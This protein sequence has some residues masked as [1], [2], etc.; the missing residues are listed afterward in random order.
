MLSAPSPTCVYSILM[1]HLETTS[2]ACHSVGRACADHMS[3]ER[4]HLKA[5]TWSTFVP[6]HFIR[7]ESAE[8]SSLR[9]CYQGYTPTGTYIWATVENGGL[10]ER[11][12][13][14]MT[15]LQCGNGDIKAFSSAQNGLIRLY[16]C[17]LR[18]FPC[19]AEGIA[20][21]PSAEESPV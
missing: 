1:A 14:T 2:G 9:I 18:S 11:A 20:K 19:G 16:A 5:D 12:A 10:S 15:L 13:G 3:G 6:P 17:W 4:G 21:R 7:P 8:T